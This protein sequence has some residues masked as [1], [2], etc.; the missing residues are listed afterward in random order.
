MIFL[1]N[2]CKGRF[3]IEC[4]DIRSSWRNINSYVGE[5]IR[6][7]RKAQ[8]LTQAQ[9]GEMV[10][11][12]QPY[13]GDI[14]RGERNISLDTLQKNLV[15]LNIKPLQLFKNY[16]TKLSKELPDMLNRLQF[17]LESRSNKEIEILIKMINNLLE[18]IDELK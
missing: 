9:L 1:I 16:D 5:R 7:Y 17:L 13:V 10:E 18:S 11:L 12:P 3:N 4:F 14:E 15:V 2:T 6:F 8:N